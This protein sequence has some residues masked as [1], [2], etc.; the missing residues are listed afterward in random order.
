MEDMKAGVGEKYCSTCGEIIRKEAEICPKCGVRQAV[1]GT[2]LSRRLA[3]GI[4]A[5]LL[6]AFGVHSFYLGKIGSG[7]IRLLFCWTGI[8]AVI[9]LIEGII[10]LTMD[11]NEFIEKYGK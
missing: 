5:I 2:S 4:L 7:I 10:Y 11:D 3:A 8:P 9:A 1:Q 6:G